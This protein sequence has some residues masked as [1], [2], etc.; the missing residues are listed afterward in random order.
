MYDPFAAPRNERGALPYLRSD[1]ALRHMEAV[2]ERT[3]ELLDGADLGESGG[4][5]LADGFVYE[6]VLRHEQQHSETILQ[7]LQIMT[8]EPTSRA[9][10]ADLPAAEPVDG[11]D[12]L[13]AG[14]AVRDGRSGARLRVRQRAPP[15]RRVTWPRS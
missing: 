3:L 1:D 11:R 10:G 7:T 5:L 9:R 14:R 8:A 13:R 4:A 15:S 2:R 12:G 6:M